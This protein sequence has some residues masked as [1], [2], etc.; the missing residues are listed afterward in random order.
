MVNFLTRTLN[1]ECAFCLSH[2]FIIIIALYT[3]IFDMINFGTKD[4]LCIFSSP[5]IYCTNTL[6]IQGDSIKG[7]NNITTFIIFSNNG[8]LV[9][10]EEIIW[11]IY[12][13]YSW[14]WITLLLL[15]HFEEV[16]GYC[17]LQQQQKLNLSIN[18]SDIL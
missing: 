17:Y 15:H 7:C 18:P 5:N 13:M 8:K 2:S 10:V 11:R 16:L 1:Q 4:C 3:Y 12:K 9:K 14:K 6:M